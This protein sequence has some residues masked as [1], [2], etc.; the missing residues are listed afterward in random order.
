MTSIENT[1]IY[2]KRLRRSVLIAVALLAVFLLVRPL[3]CFSSGKF[4]QKA[5]DC[6]KKGKCSPSNADDCCKATVQDGNQLV[7]AQAT[8]HSAPVLNVAETVV[9]GT[10]FQPSAIA[11]FV[12]TYQPPGT[13]P[14]LGFSLPLLI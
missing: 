12:E 6:C 5:A 4:D 8:D 10:T 2:L 14:D 3:D 11:R 13:P 7:T 9:L 1:E